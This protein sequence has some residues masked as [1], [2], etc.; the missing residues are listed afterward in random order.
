MVVIQKHTGDF[1]RYLERTD[2]A[3]PAEELSAKPNP[4]KS[5]PPQE[6]E[7]WPMHPLGGSLLDILS[8]VIIREVM[9]GS[10]TIGI[11]NEPQVYLKRLG[12]VVGDGEPQRIFSPLFEAYVRRSKRPGGA[13]SLHPQTRAVRRGDA[14][15]PITLTAKEDQL[16]S[17]FLEHTGQLCTKDALVRAVWPDEF[18]LEGVRDDRLAQLVR[19]LREK[20]EF[21]PAEPTYIVTVHGQGYRFVQP[22]G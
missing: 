19:R 6:L 15:L 10:L 5:H 4:R 20:I 11:E 17:Y 1:G 22:E 9:A 2:H 16:L 18:R 14:E 8:P 3:S 7:I 13:I 21:N 12:M